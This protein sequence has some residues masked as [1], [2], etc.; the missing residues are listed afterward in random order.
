[1]QRSAPSPNTLERNTTR[2][3]LAQRDAGEGASVSTRCA[4]AVQTTDALGYIV[5]FLFQR[6]FMI[7]DHGALKDVAPKKGKNATESLVLR[8]VSELVRK[9]MSIFAVIG[10]NKNAVTQCEAPGGR[11]EKIHCVGCGF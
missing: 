2:L 1:M 3:G 6:R 8:R 11:R 9:K 5:R 10:S 7:T 4:C